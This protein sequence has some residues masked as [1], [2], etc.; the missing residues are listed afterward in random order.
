MCIDVTHKIEVLEEEFDALHKGILSD[1]KANGAIS[2]EE[3]LQALTLLPISL[4]REYESS[5]Q[6]KLTALERIPT[7]SGMFLRLN[8]L[9]SFLDYGL[10]DHLVRKF[11][12]QA[13]KQDMMSYVAKINDFMSETTIA[14]LMDCWPGLEDIPASFSQLRVKF[15]EDPIHYTLKKL[16]RFRRKFCGH[17]RLSH[18][19]LLL[20][21]VES[22]SF[23][24]IW[25]VPTILVPDLVRMAK[26][27]SAGFY[28]YE[29]ILSITVDG[30][31][32][33]PSATQEATSIPSKQVDQ[34]VLFPLDQVSISDSSL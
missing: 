34:V 18:F 11:G 27:I 8:P 12:G 24:A 4:R 5:I 23:Y 25:R 28:Q 32:V 31:Y 7:I 19:I 13:L 29:R 10:L 6:E 30:D 9:F 14:Q 22:G 16:D 21:R 3:F 17:T 33:Y 15:D 2:A 20:I 26:Q 1:I